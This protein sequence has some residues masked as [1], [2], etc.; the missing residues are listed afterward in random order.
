[1]TRKRR[2]LKPKTNST[3]LLS[4]KVDSPD[5]HTIILD[6]FGGDKMMKNQNEFMHAGDVFEKGKELAQYFQI[7]ITGNPNLNKI[8]FNLRDAY[9]KADGY[10]L[11]AAINSIDGKRTKDPKPYIK[12]GIQTLSIEQKGTLSWNLFKNIL[13]QLGY[14]VETN[15]YMMVENISV[16]EKCLNLK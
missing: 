9:H 15:Q 6:V 8:C 4:K 5:D 10:V 12:E 3:D 16:M 11:F 14:N 2:V 1:M 7:V 13:E